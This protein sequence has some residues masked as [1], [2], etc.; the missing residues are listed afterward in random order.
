MLDTQ[1]EQGLQAGE[2]HGQRHRGMG[3]CEEV[4]SAAGNSLVRRKGFKWGSA[5]E[6]R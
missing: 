2:V 6:I 5:Q 4:R 3:K 1:V